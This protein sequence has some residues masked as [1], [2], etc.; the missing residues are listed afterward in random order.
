MNEALQ[1]GGYFRM[2]KGVTIDG[3]KGGEGLLKEGGFSY[4]AE[5]LTNSN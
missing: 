5:E 2:G 4:L 3:A 1:V